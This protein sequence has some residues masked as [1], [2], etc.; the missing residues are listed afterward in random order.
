MAK[1]KLSIA[2]LPAGFTLPPMAPLI[3]SPAAEAS[4]PAQND[5]K[6]TRQQANNIVANA[7][8]SSSKDKKL[9]AFRVTRPTARQLEKMAWEEDL[10]LQAFLLKTINHYRASRGLDPLPE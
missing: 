5:N 8:I 10:T 2:S 9:V 3:P 4:V 6:L 1:P 7:K